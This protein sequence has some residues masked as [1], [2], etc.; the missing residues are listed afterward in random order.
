M[1]AKEKNIVRI[2]EQTIR[3]SKLTFT[4]LANALRC[5]LRGK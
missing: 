4:E 3:N 1:N 5:A 2:F